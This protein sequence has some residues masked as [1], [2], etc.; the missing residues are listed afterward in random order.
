MRNALEVGPIPAIPPPR[1]ESKGRNEIV[2]EGGTSSWRILIS[3]FVSPLVLILLGAGIL[4]FVLG[5]WIEGVAI[6]SIVIVNSLIGFFQEFRAE[7]AV[8][9]LK[10]MTAPRATVFRKESLVVIPAIEVVRGDV[11]VL[12]AGDIVAA[13]AII[14]DSAH[15][16]VNESVLTGES[17]PVE[18]LAPGSG[19]KSVSSDPKERLFMGTSVSKGTARAEVTAI[20]METELGKIAHLMTTADTPPTPLQLQLSKVGKIL[21][22]LCFA[23]VGL[24]LILGWFHHRPWVDLLVFSISLAVAVVPEG[25]PT[26]VTVALAL[27]VRRMSALKALVRKLPSVETLG[28]VSVIC[29]DKTGTLTTGK[30]RVREISGKDEHEIILAAASCCDAEIEEDGLSGVGDPT[31][32]AILIKA[33][34]FK[35][36][37]PEIEKLNVRGVVHPFDTVRKR[38]S[39][40][41]KD[42]FLY[43]K[44]AFESIYPLCTDIQNLPEISEVNRE[45]ASRGLRV[46][47]IAR[48]LASEEK[49]LSFLGLIGIADPPRE[50][51]KVSIAEARQAGIKIVMITGDHEDTAVAIAKELGI[52]VEGESGETSVYSRA[53]PAEKLKIIRELKAKG[54]IVA[55]TGDGVNDAPALRE[56][57]IGI[58]MGKAGTEVTRQAADLILADDNFA[59]II[60]AVKEGR[61]VYQNIRRATVFLLTG[62]FG[63]LIA[64]LGASVIGMP[65]PFLASHLLWINLVT[66]SLP[67]LALVAEPVSGDVMKS[68]PRTSNELLLGRPEWFRIGW[69]GALEGGLVLALFVYTLNGDGLAHARNLCFSTLVFSQLFRSFSARSRVRVIPEIGLFSNLWL[70]GVVMITG[71]LQLGLHYIP[72]TQKVFDL[73]PLSFRDLMTILFVSLVAVTVVELK[74]LFSNRRRKP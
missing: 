62:N 32:I 68:A 66:D 70:L 64:V 28:S 6:F 36:D 69:I 40:Q 22:G 41:R 14:R 29:T 59:T 49:D 7:K 67:A 42:G 21:L 5:D 27:G 17:L 1:A 43:V 13:D 10:D 26:I 65:L 57:H 60:A 53:T 35:I 11:L 46:L 4:T 52:L 23:V 34:E 47:A 19:D 18:K 63:E 38:M 54:A 72:F 25:M 9:A 16:E 74:K 48:G 31:E 50:E 39:I 73:Q 55:M 12:E 37:R 20:G 30:M 44:G 2:S 71:G 8:L 33:R 51:A 58:A 15:L 61:G 24:V 45:M 3:Q 56:A